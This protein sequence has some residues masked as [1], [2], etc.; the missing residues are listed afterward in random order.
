MENPFANFP[1]SD[2]SWSEEN[3]STLMRWLITSGLVTN[4]ELASLMLSHLNPSQVGT[5]IASKKTFQAHFPPKKTMVEVIKW[6]INQSGKCLDCSTR[7]E[8]QADHII[9]RQVL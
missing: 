7:L 3:W 5:S 2:R 6:H 8:L 9:P 1:A 4:K